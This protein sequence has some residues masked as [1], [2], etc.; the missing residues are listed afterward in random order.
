MAFPSSFDQANVVYGPPAGMTEEQ[1]QSLSAFR[2]ENQVI[3][4]W[5]VT[6]EELE[7]IQKTGRIWVT[8][9]A[10]WIPPMYVGCD[11]P[12]KVD[13]F[14][15]SGWIFECKDVVPRAGAHRYR[16]KF[17]VKWGGKLEVQV[18]DVGFKA[19]RDMIRSMDYDDVCDLDYV[20]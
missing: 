13:E 11:S 17:D 15:G 14:G 10:S 6:R 4:C 7:M 1:V 18:G 3:T 16:L 20:I 2:D 9:M 8:T 5:K 19:F 12:F